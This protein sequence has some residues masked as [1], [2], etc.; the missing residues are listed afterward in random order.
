MADQ[1]LNLPPDY[2]GRG[3]AA[4]DTELRQERDW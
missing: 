3:K 2:E 4:I 1:P